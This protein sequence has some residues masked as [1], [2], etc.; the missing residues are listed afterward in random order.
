[1]N[2]VIAS[3]ILERTPF[4]TILRT[5]SFLLGTVSVDRP[6]Q[7]DTVKSV[8]HLCRV[9]MVTDDRCHETDFLEAWGSFDDSDRVPINFE[10]VFFPC[11]APTTCCSSLHFWT[12]Y[13][14]NF[15]VQLFLFHPLQH[16]HDYST[17]ISPGKNHFA[18][19][20]LLQDA[21]DFHLFYK[22]KFTMQT[23]AWE[24]RFGSQSR[25]L[26]W[27]FD[28]LLYCSFSMKTLTATNGTVLLRLGR[29]MSC[30]NSKVSV[31]LGEVRLF[32][33]VS[34]SHSFVALWSSSEIWTLYASD[35]TLV[36]PVCLLQETNKNMMDLFPKHA[37]A[38]SFTKSS[39]SSRTTTSSHLRLHRSEKISGI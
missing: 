23:D 6:E 16:G 35:F 3:T 24:S 9:L 28:Q 7:L 19:A 13:C 15:L 32:Y 30:S 4:F 12:T 38:L 22:R 14:Q 33:S 27:H 25:P 2:L 5:I 34:P 21:Q 11:L 1:M 8:R 31:M 39:R 10:L 36:G 18:L 37:L 20:Q 17:A 29:Y 26:L